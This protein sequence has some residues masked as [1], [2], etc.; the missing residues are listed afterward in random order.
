MMRLLRNR[1]WVASTFGF[2][3]LGA[4]GLAEAGI[5]LNLID[6]VGQTDTPYSLSFTAS[7][8]TTSVSFGGYQLPDFEYASNIGVNEGGTGPNLLGSSWTF[9][10]AAEGSDSGTF[11][12]G[13]SVPALVFGGTVVGDYDTFSQSFATTVGQSYTVDFLFSN[14]PGDDD[15]EDS[16]P[17]GFM[18][19]TSA[20]AVPEP[21]SIALMGIACLSGLAFAYRP[22][23]ERIP[24]A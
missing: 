19:T 22:R 5:L 16:S 7:D 18:V 14:D 10:P 20:S 8:T 15:P 3:M 2:L 4:S 17:S 9:T 11:Y 1:F 13:T 24:H 6:P 23:R 12:D 21:S